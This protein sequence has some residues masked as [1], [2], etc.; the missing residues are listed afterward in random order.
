MSARPWDVVTH[1]MVMSGDGMALSRLM[2]FDCPIVV[3]AVGVARVIDYGTP[4]RPHAP[5]AF[6]DDAADVTLD[7]V[8]WRESDAWELL[9][10]YTGQHGYRGAVMHASEFIGGRMALDILNT[11]GIYVALAVECEPSDDDVDR[12]PGD[13]DAARRDDYAAGAWRPEAT[14]WTVARWTGGAR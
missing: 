9:T 8:P 11:P 3:D 5:E 1:D 14:G 4:G 7:G 6:H 2:E 13:S 12:W 10:G